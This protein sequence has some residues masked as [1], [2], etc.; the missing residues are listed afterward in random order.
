M[1]NSVCPPLAK[2]I[3]MAQFAAE[4]AVAKP[5]RKAA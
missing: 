1:T 2:A 5:R 4:V 3:V